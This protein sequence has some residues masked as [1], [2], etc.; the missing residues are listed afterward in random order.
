MTNEDVRSSNRTPIAIKLPTFYEECPD[1]YFLQ[2]EGIFRKKKIDDSWDRYDLLLEA[3]SP[4]Q[5]MKLN[6]FLQV[7]TRQAP[8]DIYDRLKAKLM[9]VFQKSKYQR[10]TALLA[11]QG[12]DIGDQKPSEVLQEMRNLY[13]DED[14][15]NSLF[16]ALFLSRM[17]MPVKQALSHEGSFGDLDKAGQRADEVY[18]TCG[19]HAPPIM[20]ISKFQAQRGRGRNL[21]YQQPSRANDPK[22]QSP[23]KKICWWH[24]NFGQDAR[25][26]EPS[27]KH[28]RN[29]NSIQ[30][31]QSDMD[32]LNGQSGHFLTANET[33]AGNEE[34]T[35]L[36]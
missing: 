6:S 21:R 36:F 14:A 25:S 32:S 28:Y 8:D 12:K 16:I 20:H 9:D 31:V 24:F 19:G 3:L 11:L 15:N 17:P 13:G 1:S 35:H 27:C 10:A 7:L 23:Q 30:S 29:K 26:C 4:Q 34:G 2:I 5:A 22:R 18:I 33:P